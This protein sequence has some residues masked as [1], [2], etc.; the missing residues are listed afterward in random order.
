MTGNIA[1]SEV[2]ELDSLGREKQLVQVLLIVPRND[3]R[4]PQRFAPQATC[5]SVYKRIKTD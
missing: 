5:S 2:K 3:D 4:H 1:G